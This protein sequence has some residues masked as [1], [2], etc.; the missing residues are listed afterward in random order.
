VDI[1]SHLF[2]EGQPVSGEAVWIDAADPQKKL[3][4]HDALSWIKRLGC[5]LDRIGVGHG[6]VVMI[7]TPNH[8]FVP[9]AYLGIVG[10]SRAFSAINP[11]YTVSEATYQLKN[12]GAQCIIVHPSLIENAVE[13]AKAAGLPK[14]RI[15]QFSDEPCQA[16]LGVQD[17]SELL[18]IP[19]DAKQWR[20]KRLSEQ[21]SVQT[22]ATINY[23]S[24]TTGLPKG[25]CISHHNLIANLEQTVFMRWPKLKPGEPSNER[26]VG[27]KRP[28][29]T[30]IPEDRLT[31]SREI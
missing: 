28:C 12:T 9:A 31:C 25:V 26:W 21:E 17:W 24:G 29:H 7:Y 13:A 22:V 11:I 15:F 4:P 23:S 30:L 20:W 3:S 1:L 19:Q 14:S 5:G 16:R 18:A 2:P 8:I 27:C 10:S 6:E